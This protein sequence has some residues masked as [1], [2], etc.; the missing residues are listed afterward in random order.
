LAHHINA[1]LNESFSE[2]FWFNF[3]TIQNFIK[4]LLPC[5]LGHKLFEFFYFLFQNLN[6][7]LSLPSLNPEID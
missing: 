7:L 6:E 3:I 2:S 5:K 4:L 1:V